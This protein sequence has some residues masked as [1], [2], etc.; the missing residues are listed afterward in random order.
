MHNLALVNSMHKADTSAI[1]KLGCQAHRLGPMRLGPAPQQQPQD[2]TECLIGSALPARLQADGP[3][4][5]SSTSRCYFPH[6]R[7]ETAADQDTCCRVGE[8]ASAAGWRRRIVIRQSLTN[9]RRSASIHV[10]GNRDC[11]SRGHAIEH[12]SKQRQVGCQQ[13]RWYVWW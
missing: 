3:T 11:D 7:S 13:V 2:I 6:D 5:R 10:L 4:H 12:K 1:L 9:A 8:P